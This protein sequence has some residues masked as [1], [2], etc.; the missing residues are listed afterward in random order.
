MSIA[1]SEGEQISGN[2]EQERTATTVNEITSITNIVG[3]SWAQ[4]VYNKAGNLTTIPRQ[5]PPS[6]SPLTA[7]DW[8]NLPADGW[9]EV[10]AIH[11]YEPHGPSLHVIQHSSLTTHL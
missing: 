1:I 8:G 2:L 9:D 11:V 5:T 7:N 4:P 3:S 6:W 10:H